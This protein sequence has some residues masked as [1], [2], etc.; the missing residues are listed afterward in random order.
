MGNK[1]SK[2]ESLIKIE[3]KE[4]KIKKIKKFDLILILAVVFTVGIFAFFVTSNLKEYRSTAVQYKL[5]FDSN[6]GSN[7]SSTDV[8]G[9]YIEL[10]TKVKKEGYIFVGWTVDGKRVENKYYVKKDTSFKAEWKKKEVVENNKE[11]EVYSITFNYNYDDKTHIEK[12][13]YGGK[14]AKPLDPVREGYKFKGWEYRGKAYDFDSVIYNDFTID[15]KWEKEKENTDDKKE[16]TG[17][18]D[19]ETNNVDKVSV[20][21]VT[22]NLNGGGENYTVKVNSGDKVKEPSTPEREGYKFDGWYYND[23]VYNFNNIVTKDIT[24]VAKWTKN[25][26]VKY[27]VTFNSNNGGVSTVDVVS[28]NTVTKPANDP[29]KTGYKFLGWYTEDKTKFDFSTKI[30][31]NITLYA[32][33]GPGV[34][35]PNSKMIFVT[36]PAT[37]NSNTYLADKNFGKKLLY[38]GSVTGQFEIYYSHKILS[39]LLN[40]AYYAVRIYNPNKEVINVRVNNCGAVVGDNA[41]VVWGQYYNKGCNIAGETYPINAYK[42]IIIFHNGTEFICRNVN[43][44]SGVAALTGT[45]EGV[46]NITSPKEVFVSTLVFR[47]IADTYE[48]V[49]NG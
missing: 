45:V 25:K 22:F 27:K 12:V 34:I 38:K 3:K 19:K 43:D 21:K 40:N 7:V 17:D 33:W 2:K 23:K 46:L 5:V 47:R 35:E 42:S 10:P 9:G 15:A 29:V 37:L 48:A 30:L 11:P 44:Q 28:G 24:L 41:S 39:P 16:P 36:K 31:G 1:E 6:G 26:V 32:L 20:Y 18:S 49:F 8:K 13:V 4:L 14:V